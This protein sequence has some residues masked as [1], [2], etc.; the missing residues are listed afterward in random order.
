M[1]L[2]GLPSYLECMACGKGLELFDSKVIGNKKLTDYIEDAISAV[3]FISNKFHPR[4][5][6][7]QIVV[8]FGR[9]MIDVV[10]NHLLS[11]DRICNEILHVCKK[12]V[13]TKIDLQGV[14]DG[15]LANKPEAI[16]EDNF[17]ND[18]YA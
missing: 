16:Q 2:Q 1:D 11:K 6:S 5:A 9:P 18:L 12:P 10:Q 14:V 17:I 8:Q 7:K 15:I 3:I 4:M 13:I